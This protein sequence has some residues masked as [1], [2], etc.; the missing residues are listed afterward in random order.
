MGKKEASAGIM[1]INEKG[2][3]YGRREEDYSDN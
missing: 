1:V 3:Y 2:R